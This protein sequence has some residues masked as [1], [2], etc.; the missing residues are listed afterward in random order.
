MNTEKLKAFVPYIAA[1]VIFILISFAYFPEV[2]EGK[3]LSPHD[4]KTW[5]GG[6]QEVIN[7]EKETGEHSLWTNS[8]FSGM[9]AYL[10]SN[11]TPNNWVKPINQTLNANGKLRPVSFIFWA[12]LAMF[13]ALLLFEVNPWLSIAGAI[14]YGFSSYFFIIIEA[15]HATKMSALA[16]MPAIIGGIYHAYKKDMLKGALVM[17]I[18]FALQLYRNHLQITYYTLMIIGIFVVF[19][20]VTV[21]KSKEFKSFFITSGVLFAAAMI[22]IMANFTNIATTYDYG[23]D[24][25]RGKSELTIDT[26][27]QTDGLD[28]DY[29][30]AW[31]YGKLETF[32]LL[33]PNLVG[34]SSISALPENSKMEQELK[35]LGVKGANKIVKQMPTYWGPQPMTSGPVYIG[36][37]IVFL[38]VLGMFLVKSEIR[39]WLFSATVLSVLLAWGNNFTAF[40]EFFLDY[41]PGYNKFRTVS[42]I[43][44]IAE[45]A[46]PLLGILALKAIIDKDVTRKEIL[47]ATAWAGGIVGGIILILLLNPGILSF[48]SANDASWFMR[49]FGLGADAQ[50]KQILDGL[51][52]ALEADRATMFTNDA[53]RSLGF[54][55]VGI[56]LIMLYI[57][58]KLPQNGF[59][60]LMA[61][62]ILVDLWGVNKRYLNSDDFV[63]KRKEKVP[64]KMQIANQEILKDTGTYR[65]ANLAVSTFNDASTSYFHHSIGGYHGA[66]MRRYQELIDYRI[67]QEFDR[68]RTGLNN[69]VS[70]S[71]VL[72]TLSNLPILNMLNTKYYII[73]PNGKPLQNPLAYGNAWFVDNLVKVQ[74]PDEEIAGIINPYK[75]DLV[76]KTLR[77]R[78]KLV[79]EIQE[80]SAKLQKL[81]S[82]NKITETQTK[83]SLDYRKKLN[84]LQSVE[85][86]LEA[87]SDFN[88][89]QV[90][91]ADVKYKEQF[92]DF[93]KDPSATIELTDYKPNQ[94]TYKSKAASDQLAVFSEIYYG[95]KGWNAYLDGKLVP[96]FRVDYVLRAM[97]IPA[98][99]HE[100]IFKFEPKIW[101]TASTVALIGSILFVLII[102]GFAVR[103]FKKSKTK[104]TEA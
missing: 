57:Y 42:M 23:K 49:S 30:M 84:M 48:S 78:A 76:L 68:F 26:K 36:A 27:H 19:H 81:N 73:D 47:N 101:K 75:I 74:N 13:I 67:Q 12:M 4:I 66:K 50:S 10:I 90:A 80:I 55:A 46:L 62:V 21:I 34:G 86:E 39:W 44:V 71:M 37:L 3:Q 99:E 87:L 102:I 25:I 15:G 33:I 82:S 69:A 9:P 45:F 51:V 11:Y 38:F 77:E 56:G 97:K 40:S 1:L 100:I 28:K 35:S 63:S 20:F 22:A 29:A 31:S 7:F 52:S 5:K 64:Y 61:L 18:F 93:T 53:L 104:I 83:L 96:H 95:E 89:V 60:A 98:G 92:F 14:A 94:L 103:Q 70:D 16:Y 43:L 54:I 88:P 85:N 79:G 91:V 65:V 2:L 8:M 72:E 41:V 32:N 59:Y 6:A 58:E 17:M 24:S